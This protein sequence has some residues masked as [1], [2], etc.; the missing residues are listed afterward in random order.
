MVWL[1]IN[2]IYVNKAGIYDRGSVQDKADANPEHCQMINLQTG[3]TNT[4]EKGTD[5]TDKEKSES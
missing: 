1:N 2:H 5:T 4:E 3:T